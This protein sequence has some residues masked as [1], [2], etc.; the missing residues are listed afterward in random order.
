VPFTRFALVQK[1]DFYLIQLILSGLTS[2]KEIVHIA[3]SHVICLFSWRRCESNESIQ[4]SSPHEI[5]NRRTLERLKLRKGI[6][7]IPL[8]STVSACFIILVGVRLTFVLL[9]Y[10][11]EAVFPFHR[12]VLHWIALRTRAK[13][14]TEIM[15]SILNWEL[16]VKLGHLNCSI[17]DIWRFVM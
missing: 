5:V 11:H 3:K 4:L 8:V 6:L 17:D 16:S 13:N 10:S 15:Y 12:Q 1:H 9:F 14:R 7:A 2:F